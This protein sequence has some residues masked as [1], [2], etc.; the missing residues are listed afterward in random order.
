MNDTYIEEEWND[1]AVEDVK[2]KGKESGGFTK[3]MA[4]KTLA[5]R[6]TMTLIQSP[7]YVC[8]HKVR[9]LAA[10]ELYNKH[11]ASLPWDMTAINPPFVSFPR[12][13][14]ILEVYRPLDS[15]TIGLRP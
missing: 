13:T 1:E 9:V 5:E 8:L 10:W 11:K 12:L 15:A 6:G 2:A 4:S 7:R 14:S 3:Y